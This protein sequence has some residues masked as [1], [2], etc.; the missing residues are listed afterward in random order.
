MEPPALTNRV[1]MPAA[2]ETDLQ[3]PKYEIHHASSLAQDP[4]RPDPPIP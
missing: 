2:S 1:R 4:C 3:E